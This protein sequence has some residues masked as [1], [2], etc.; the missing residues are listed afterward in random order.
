MLHGIRKAMWLGV[1]TS[2]RR[3]GDLV[4]RV[5][6]AAN[7]LARTFEPWGVL[8]AFVGVIVAS[9]G[10]MIDLED[11]QSA[12]VFRAWEVVLI[13]T[14][15]PPE[16]SPDNSAPQVRRTGSSTRQAMQYLNRQF[17]GA[18]CFWW[19]TTLSKQLT[20]ND[21]R[22]CIFPAK[23][24]EALVSLSLSYSNLSNAR[25]RSAELA[26]S[27]LRGTDLAT[28][29]LRDANLQNTDLRGADLEG[30]DL[31]GANLQG[32]C[33][34]SS[35]MGPI[36]P[37]N[38]QKTKLSDADLRNADLK[39]A[40]LRGADLRRADLRGAD[41]REWEGVSIR[42]DGA[43]LEGVKLMNVK[44]IDCIKLRQADGWERAYRDPSLGCGAEVPAVPEIMQEDDVIA[45]QLCPGGN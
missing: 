39:G 40:D 36:Y 25:L 29:D 23:Q 4:A 11:R 20:G 33:L 14:A 34:S 26:R 31:R 8:C 1:S 30:T 37:T 42:W 17:A 32:A 45:Y 22:G 19:V 9:V 41:L 28:A 43:Q 2:A 18:G 21:H 13:A 10:L 27:A 38:L 24:R 7:R 16:A 15:S 35:L 44:G 12:R 3:G 6:A 5:P